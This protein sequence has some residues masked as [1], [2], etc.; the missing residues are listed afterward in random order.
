MA[1]SGDCYTSSCSGES[2]NYYWDLFYYQAVLFI[3]LFPWC[4]DCAHILHCTWSDIHTR[5][6]LDPDGTLPGCYYWLQRHKAFGEC[7]RFGSYNRYACH[8]MLNVTG[9]C[10]LLEQE[11]LPCPWFPAFL[12]H[13]RSTLLLSFPC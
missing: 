12:W 13:N 4:E 3:K 2:S 11:Y 6:Q 5:N 9:Y 7:T 8:H 1:C 10:A